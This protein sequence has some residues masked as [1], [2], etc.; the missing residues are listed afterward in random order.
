MYLVNS[1]DLHK[2]K[3]FFPTLRVDPCKPEIFGHPYELT[4]GGG[5]IPKKL[6]SNSGRVPVINFCDTNFDIN[7][8]NKHSVCAAIT[9]VVQLW[10]L[11][12]KER[13]CTDMYIV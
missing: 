5:M 9:N 13:A 8:Y 7:G 2:G 11:W 12:I 4:C 6:Q 1:C 10:S 3:V